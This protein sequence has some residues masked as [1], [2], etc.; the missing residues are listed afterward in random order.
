MTK[1]VWSP[2]DE[3]FLSLRRKFIYEPEAEVDLGHGVI[4]VHLFFIK[5]FTLFFFFTTVKGTFI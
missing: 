3:F 1:K 5:I 4:G 2:F